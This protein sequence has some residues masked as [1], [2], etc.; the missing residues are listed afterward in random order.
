MGVVHQA[1]VGWRRW[2]SMHRLL[3]AWLGE[4]SDIG[5]LRPLLD[6]LGHQRNLDVACTES[7]PYWATSWPGEATVWLDALERLE[8]ERTTH[9]EH[10][11]QCMADPG[12]G[13]ALWALALGLWGMGQQAVPIRKRWARQRLGRWHRKLQ[14]LLQHNAQGMVDVSTLHEARLLAKRLRYGSEAMAGVLSSRRQR[15]AAKWMAEATAWQTRIGQ[16]RDAWQAGACLKE[17]GAP[18]TVV[19]FLRGVAAS[20]DRAAQDLVDQS[21]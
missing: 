11:R 3:K 19:F 16:S 1:R 4:P 15:E 2:R 10:L 8:A 7:L 20:M 6:A 17:I 21:R 14:R 13:L 5:P 18:E 9:R 12:T